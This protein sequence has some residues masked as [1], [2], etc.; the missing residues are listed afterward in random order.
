MAKFEETAYAKKVV[1]WLENR[2][3]E[4]FKEVEAPRDKRVVDIYAIKGDKERPRNTWAIEVKTG[5]T[6]RVME[7]ASF[8]KRHAHQTSVAIPADIDSRTYDFGRRVC[9]EFGLGVIEVVE[10][11]NGPAFAK[12]VQHSKSSGVATFPTLHEKQKEYEAGNADNDH[13]SKFD[14]FSDRLV[15]YVGEHPGASLRRAITDL[16]HHY[17]SED[18]A[19]TTLKRAIKNRAIPKLIIEWRHS[20][21]LLF[22]TDN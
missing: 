7:Q 22:R 12:R 3:W 21:P 16:D 6:L 11:D 10:Y 8:W 5:F 1:E 15:E 18:S 20:T 2:D 17:K 14:Q 9:T 13:Y 19:Y 4:V